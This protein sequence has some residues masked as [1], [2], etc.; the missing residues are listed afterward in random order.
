VKRGTSGVNA[1]IAID[2]PC[3]MTSHDVVSRV[4]RYIGEGRVGHA[5]T[6]DPDASGVLVVGIGQGTRL[7][8]LLTL[9]RKGYEAVI[10]FGSETDTCDA[11]GEVVSTS[12]VP[13]ELSDTTQ[14]AAY[15]S[16]LVGPCEQV[17]PNYSAISVG[18]RRSYER[19]RAGEDFELPAR[20][21]EIL[22]SSLISVDAHVGE[23]GAASVS[24][25]CSFVVSK[26]CY[27]RSIAR[28]MGRDLGCGAHLSALGRTSSGDIDLDSCHTL[29]EIAEAGVDGIVALALDP[30]AALGLPVRRLSADEV[31]PASCGR[32]LCLGSIEGDR[33]PADGDSVC[34]L[35]PDRLL[36]GVWHVEGRHLVSSVN[37]ACGISGVRA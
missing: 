20:R 22:S 5:G 6:L 8:G 23:G 28:D 11:S 30:V 27:I 37:F 19:A 2:K 9:D 7:M 31:G 17:P 3:G 1:L 26:G 24:W 14:A 16:T 12:P 4:R 32:R 21:V 29:D 15:L 13:R 36:A 25:R 35:T 34:L 33:M 18:G 10:E